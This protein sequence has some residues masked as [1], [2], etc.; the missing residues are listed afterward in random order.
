MFVEN[1]STLKIHKLTQE[2]YDRELAEGNIDEYSLYLT[3]EKDV[4]TRH[5]PKTIYLAIDNWVELTQEIS[6]DEVTTDNT[7]IISSAPSCIEAYKNAEVYCFSQADKSLTFKC[8]S[9]PTEELAVN[10]LILN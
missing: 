9:V 6:V 10:V 4:Q 1:L 5:I 7:I 2:Q 8:S 3:P